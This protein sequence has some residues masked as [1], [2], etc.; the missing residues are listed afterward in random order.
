ME[1]AVLKNSWE[2]LSQY[3]HEASGWTTEESGSIPGR[4]K[5]FFF[6]T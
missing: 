2:K 4:D 5:R 3:S 1:N 6:S